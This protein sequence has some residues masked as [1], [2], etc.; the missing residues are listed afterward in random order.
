MQTIVIR[1]QGILHA[2]AIEA[3]SCRS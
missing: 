3:A 1:D 2:K